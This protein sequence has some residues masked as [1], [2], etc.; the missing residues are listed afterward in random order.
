MDP[1]SVVVRR[2]DAALP[3]ST[4]EVVHELWLAMLER[5]QRENKI[6]I[7]PTA[8]FSAIDA[9]GIRLRAATSWLGDNSISLA[10]MQL[11]QMLIQYPKLPV[12]QRAKLAGTIE[13]E[14]QRLL[15][16]VRA[17]QTK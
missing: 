3:A 13:K 16:R 15:Q 4:A 8:V 12:A 9:H 7:A 10:M 14:G 1:K 2:Y 11:G 6:Q 5:S 17:I